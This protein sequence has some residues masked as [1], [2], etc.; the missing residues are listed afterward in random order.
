MFFFIVN[1]RSTMNQE[2][3]SP[4]LYFNCV[5]N[6]SPV[7]GRYICV[8]VDSCPQGANAKGRGRRSQSPLWDNFLNFHGQLH[9]GIFAFLHP[10]R[11]LQDRGPRRRYHDDLINIDARHCVLV[12][13]YRGLLLHECLRGMRWHVLAHHGNNEGRDRP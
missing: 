11:E 10:R 1:V 9:G 7:R 4:Y 8:H 3:L 6:S 12:Q 13:R 2:A 5:V